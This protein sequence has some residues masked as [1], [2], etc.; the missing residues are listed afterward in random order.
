MAKA[1]LCRHRL[2]RTGN[3]R[4]PYGT[5]MPSAIAGTEMEKHPQWVIQAMSAGQ[6][7]EHFSI[8]SVVADESASV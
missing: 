7:L 8:A 4:E 6:S 3:E 1:T 2:Q 5:G